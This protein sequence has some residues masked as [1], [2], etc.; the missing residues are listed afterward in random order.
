VKF[1][2]KHLPNE[3]DLKQPEGATSPKPRVKKK[4]KEH[5]PV[6]R[7]ISIFVVRLEILF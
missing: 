1:K 2:K 4:H 7:K 6:D 3:K 5:W